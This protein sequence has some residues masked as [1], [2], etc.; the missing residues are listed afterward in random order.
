MDTQE[1]LHRLLAKMDE[2]KADNEEMLAEIKAARK[3]DREERIDG[4]RR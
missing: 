2:T 3:A 4:T 1:M